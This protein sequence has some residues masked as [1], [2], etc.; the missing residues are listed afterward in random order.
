[1]TKS[2]LDSLLKLPP[3]DR[4]ELAMTLWESLGEPQRSAG[5]SL[6][7]DQIAELDR[8]LADHLA[9]PSSAVPWEDVRRRLF[10]EG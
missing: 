2:A 8:R 3:D 6:T 7:Q 5:F 1:M 10:R 4:A 9:D